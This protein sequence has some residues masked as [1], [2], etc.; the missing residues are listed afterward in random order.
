V[1]ISTCFP[2]CGD[3]QYGLRLNS[4]VDYAIAGIRAFGWVVCP[5][6]AGVNLEVGG[7]RETGSA[8]GRWAGNGYM[9]FGGGKYSSETWLSVSFSL[10]KLCI[11]SD[12][13]LRICI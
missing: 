9:T 3:D 8:A 11:S 13:I 10:R 2:T 1:N 12:S 4:P 7:H 6:K 5:N